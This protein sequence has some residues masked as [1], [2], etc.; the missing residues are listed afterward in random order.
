V[1]KRTWANLTSGSASTVNL[2]IALLVGLTAIMLLPP[3][4]L[5]YPRNGVFSDATLAHWPNAHFLRESVWQYGQWPLW[6]PTE[7]LG[8]PFA[9]NPLS[10]VWYPPQWLVLVPGPSITLALNL[11][12]YAHLIFGALGILAWA[13]TADLSEK[14]GAFAALSFALT[15]KVIAH[16]GAGHLDLVYAMA[17]AAWLMWAV[18]RYAHKPAL[19][20]GIM[21]GIVAALT[22]LADMRLAAY[23]MGAGLVYAVS[24][25]WRA[26]SLGV[27]ALI[28]V[29]LTAVYTVPLAAGTSLLTRSTISP[30]EAGLF[31]LLPGYLLGTLVAN[32]GGHHEWMTYLGLP[33]LALAFLA[34]RTRKRD[35]WVW[36][37][38][39]GLAGLYALGDHTPLYRG[40]IRVVPL[41]TWLRVPSR[42]FFMVA[43]GIAYLS[44]YGAQSLL[45]DGMGHVGR[46]V[47]VGLAGMGLFVSTGALV[48]QQPALGGMGLAL[49][50][51]GAGLL[52]A[53]RWPGWAVFALGGV[54]FVSLVALDVT[55][56]EGRREADAFRADIPPRLSNAQGTPVRFYSPSFSILPHEAERAGILTLHGVNPYQLAQSA[57]IIDRAAGVTGEGYSITAPRLSGEGDPSS[58]LRE[59]QPNV[60]LLATLSV[61]QVVSEFPIEADGLRQIET[62]PYIYEVDGARSL[63]YLVAFEGADSLG[64]LVPTAGRANM[65]TLTPNK[66]V[67]EVD[68]PN[69]ALLVITQAWTPA[70]IARVDSRPVAIMGTSA[71]TIGVP[72][73]S[74]QHRVELVYRPTPDFVGSAISSVTA[75][76]LAAWGLVRWRKAR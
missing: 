20:A 39:V 50:G 40:L 23:G 43:L 58:A 75:L 71:T 44:A 69:Q 64:S 63:A 51:T 5:P 52:L 9:A 54:L 65:E 42:A 27:A 49:L 61:Q 56:V 47:G 32:P 19:N 16:L 15:P 25:R 12:V 8:A 30:D 70:W 46:L 74:G 28:L 1:I 37:G 55:L 35:V 18:R 22:A 26:K 60:E 3:D 53:V 13:R 33:A 45:D 66:V 24:L 72:V 62:T 10:K 59:A 73:S 41:L 57:A 29:L 11:L 14:A 36:W 38:I 76:A 6:R 31:S 2:L 68:S 21:L 34:I 67:V 48:M 4:R 7:M 17:W